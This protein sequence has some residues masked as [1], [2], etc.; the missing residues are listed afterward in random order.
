MGINITITNLIG[1]NIK[2]YTPILFRNRIKI[3]R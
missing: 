2:N 1:I 3:A